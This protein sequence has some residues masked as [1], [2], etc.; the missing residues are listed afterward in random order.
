VLARD[1]LRAIAEQVDE[2]LIDVDDVSLR[3][4][5]DDRLRAREEVPVIE[6]DPVHRLEPTRCGLT[7]QGQPRGAPLDDD[8][9]RT[10][11]AREQILSVGL[12]VLQ[13]SRRIG[14][15]S[16]RLGIEGL[17]ETGGVPSGECRE[18]AWW[19]GHG[20]I[21]GELHHDPRLKPE[22]RP[23]AGLRLAQRRP[24]PRLATERVLEI[25]VVR[26]EEM[27]ECE[28]ATVGPFAAEPLQSVERGPGE[29]R[30]ERRAHHRTKLGQRLGMR[31]RTAVRARRSERIV[32]VCIRE[33]S[34]HERNRFTRQAIRISIAVVPFVMRR[35]W[36]R[37]VR[38]VTNRRDHSTGIRRVA[39]H[40][41]QL[42][43]AERAHPIDEATRHSDHPDVVEEPCPAD[44]PRVDLVAERLG[45]AKPEMGDARR[46]AHRVGVLGVDDA[47]EH[48]QELR[49]ELVARDA[50]DPWR[51]RA[52]R[53]QR[54]VELR[55]IAEQT[56][57]VR[58]TTEQLG[59]RV[60]D[61]RG[62][63]RAPLARDDSSNPV[64]RAARGRSAECELDLIGETHDRRAERDFGA[65][66]LMWEPGAVESLVVITNDVLERTQHCERTDDPG[67]A[68]RMLT[69]LRSVALVQRVVND[70]VGDAHRA[71]IVQ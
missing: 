14:E 57:Q 29:M 67:A 56:E 66:L 60:G 61:V 52:E 39:T 59:G 26:F 48:P 35:R 13:R 21:F 20:E 42:V 69:E 1:L 64:D 32:D 22:Q 27:R 70:P 8:L 50:L 17:V 16:H 31:H 28:P 33:D 46:M 2:T 34:T 36:E 24:R 58:R 63:T 19:A 7:H 37:E 40:Q 41:S 3:V 47:R 15:P 71:Q 12:E 23:A 11:V 30:I 62:N 9:D 5:K 25:G 68:L 55:L 10:A 38:E 51:R 18:R 44:V 53:R 43:V 6:R 4:R 65:S 54:V 49:E 45:D